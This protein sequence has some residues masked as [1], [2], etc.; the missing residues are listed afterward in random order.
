MN[1]VLWILQVL[2]ALAFLAHGWLFLSPPPHLVEAMNA[3]FAPA[4]RIFLGVAEILSA[5]GLILPTLTRIHAWLTPVA[6]VALSL[7][8]GSATVLHLS[9]GEF[10]SAATTAILCVLLLFVA[11]MRWHR[12]ETPPRN[13]PVPSEHFGA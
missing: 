8:V 9:R 3:A 12:K 13:V 11:T 1:I 7:V 4:F 5:I 10:S 6:A 2:L